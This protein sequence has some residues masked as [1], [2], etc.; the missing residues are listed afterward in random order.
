LSKD[1][2]LSTYENF[3]IRKNIAMNQNTPPE[4]FIILAEDPDP[5]INQ[6]VAENSNAPSE[7]LIKILEKNP[8]GG[9][10]AS[11]AYNKNTPL[12]AL[13]T[14]SKDPDEY[15]R[16]TVAQN[17]TYIKYLE[18]NKSL[19]ERWNRILKIRD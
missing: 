5:L 3:Y 10:R 17:P 12:E 2:T 13:I 7:A 16:G 8:D 1:N 18:S 11:I 4:A 6:S 14:L 19:S 15:V 9:T